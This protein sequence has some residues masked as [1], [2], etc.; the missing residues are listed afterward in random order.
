[1]MKW[2]KKLFKFWAMN[3]ER[4][5]KR[6]SVAIGAFIIW[7]LATVITDPMYSGA[8][9][10]LGSIIVMSIFGKNGNGQEIEEEDD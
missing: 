10:T 9:I 8:I 4:N 1:M 7:A 3:L 2:Y 5:V 6:I